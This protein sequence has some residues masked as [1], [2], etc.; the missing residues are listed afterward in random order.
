[1]RI[2]DLATCRETTELAATPSDGP[3]IVVSRHGDR[4]TQ[5]IVFRGRTVLTVHETYKGFPAG[6]PGP[7]LLKGTSP[8]KKWILSTIDP[9]GSASLIADG[10]E[11]RAV[12][13]T[14]GRSYAVA[15]GLGYADYRA[16]CASNLLIVTAG[17][18]R[19]ASDNK[20]LIV[21]GPPSWHA[22]LLVN[23]PTRAFG[24]VACAP[25]GESVVV[26][27]TP[28]SLDGS[29]FH[30]KWRLWRIWFS[31]GSQ[32]RLT[33]PPA[34]YVDESPHFSPDERTIYFVRSKRGSGQLYALRGGEV[35]GPL[36]SLGYS[37]GYYG[38]NAWPYS[39]K[40]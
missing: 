37:M 39:V 2:V 12:R 23:E 9:Q 13:A 32:K 26:Q 35:I 20:R 3:R 19:I 10:I 28:Q 36:L 21:T 5:S 33:T 29:F 31:N 11:T 8:D 15:S 7:I 17:G 4:G 40:R 30:T 1:M 6:S 18:D 34:G 14:G 22:R 16:W 27:E 38:A 25:D 24:S